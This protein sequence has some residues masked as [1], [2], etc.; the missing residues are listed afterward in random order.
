MAATQDEIDAQRSLV[1]AYR[2]S[3]EAALGNQSYKMPDGR[4]LIR[5]PL[6]DL[7]A[8]YRQAQNDLNAMTGSSRG[9]VRRGIAVFR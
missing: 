9:R 4:E 3:I 5:A 8:G 6:K 2:A 1:A 7:Q